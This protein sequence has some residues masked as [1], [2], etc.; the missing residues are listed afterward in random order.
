MPETMTQKKKHLHILGTRGIPAAYSGFEYLAEALAR[1]LVQRGWDVTVYC[2]EDVETGHTDKGSGQV[3]QPWSDVWEGITRLHIPT[4]KRGVLTTFAFDWQATKLAVQAHKNRQDH[5]EHVA[6]VLGYNTAAFN[7]LMRVAGMS[8]MFNM[9]GLEW[10]R[11]KWP[12]HGKLWFYLNEWIAAAIG[13]KFIADN[14]GIVAHLKRRF[15]TKSVSM[16]A[17]GAPRYDRADNASP[18]FQTDKDK[19]AELGIKPNAYALVIARSV[20]ENSIL[21]IV[22]AWGQRPRPCP[23]VILGRYYPEANPFHA[24]VIA[25]VKEVNLTHALSPVKMVGAIYDE[26]MIRPLRSWARLYIHGHQVGGTNPSL[27]EALGAGSAILAH[28]NR[29][30]RWVAGKEAATYFMSADQLETSLTELS[31]D[32][33]VIARMRE[34]AH[35]RHQDAFQWS[36]ILSDYEQF[37]LESTG[38][39]GHELPQ[40]REAA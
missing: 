12:W 3:T 1:Y 23:L 15:L 35:Q 30:N 19:L 8:L 4:K 28:G 37:L 31:H 27:V 17:Y 9:D 20:P 14:P 40:D 21:E 34:A 7:V 29:F 36:D 2:Q 16:I 18:Q 22:Q 33:V 38:Q 25:K 10:K 11:S 32:D 26:E 24:K 6:L 39:S 13:Q 5:E